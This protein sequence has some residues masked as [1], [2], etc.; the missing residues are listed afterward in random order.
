MVEDV[1]NDA[2]SRMKKSIEAARREMAGIRTGR[3]SPSLVEHLTVDYHGTATPLAHLATITATEAS[4]LTIQ[5]WD[6][7]A[8]GDIQK[9]I[10]KSDLGITPSNDG[11]VIRLAI[12][13]LTRE[14][15][16]EL[17]RQVRKK[18]EDGRVSLRNIRRDCV[19]VIRAKEKRKEVS[20]DDERRASEQLQK[21]TD[22]FIGELDQVGRA[23]ESEVM[24]V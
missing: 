2:E 14:R 22:T 16:Q 15:R 10:Q 21:L 18:V 8:I 1:L 3:A 12:P 7:Q 6:R 24:E 20:E 13:Q 11:A 19:D 23:K 4:L 9:A 17:V 5:P